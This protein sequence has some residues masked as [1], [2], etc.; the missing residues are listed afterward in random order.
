MCFFPNHLRYRQ[1]HVCP[2]SLPLFFFFFEILTCVLQGDTLAPY[3][4]SRIC[5]NPFLLGFLGLWNAR[6]WGAHWGRPQYLSKDKSDSYET[7]HSNS[8]SWGEQF[9]ANNLVC[10]L[11]N[12]LYFCQPLWITAWNFAHECLLSM[13]IDW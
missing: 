10:K 7:Y 6:G 2:K 1:I 13:G 9:G 5:F 12:V 8:V 3:N 4:L 11:L